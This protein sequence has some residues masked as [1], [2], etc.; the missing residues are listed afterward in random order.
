LIGIEK[1]LLDSIK[2]ILTVGKNS[3]GMAHR[4]GLVPFDKVAK[5]VL[6]TRLALFD[7]S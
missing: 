1:R 2:S 5:R 7:G 3:Q 4:L 6:V